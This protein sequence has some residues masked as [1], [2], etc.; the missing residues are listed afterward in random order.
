MADADFHFSTRF[1]RL[2]LIRRIFLDTIYHK[3]TLFSSIK[4]M[5]INSYPAHPVDI[6]AY[7]I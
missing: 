3:A 1:S 2:A 5:F 6:L 4:I 7:P